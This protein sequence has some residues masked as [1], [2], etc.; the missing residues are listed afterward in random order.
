LTK[1]TLPGLEHSYV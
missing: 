1:E